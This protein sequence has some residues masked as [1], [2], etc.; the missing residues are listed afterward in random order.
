MSKKI[1]HQFF[2]MAIFLI[3][4]FSTS[5]ISYEDV[6]VTDIKSVELQE[7]SGKNIKIAAEVEIVN[8]NNY[9]ISVTDSEFHISTANNLLGSFKVDNQLNIPKSSKEY[10]ELVF[11]VDM[12]DLAPNA[13]STLLQIALSGKE[14][15]NIKVEGFIEA[16]AFM[17]KRK[18]PIVFEDEVDIGI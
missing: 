16:K 18:Y 3:L 8:P 7:F 12:K 11:K 4:P 13:Q 1:F 2:G 9:S 14:E 5:C 10:H 15:M 17:L 6:N